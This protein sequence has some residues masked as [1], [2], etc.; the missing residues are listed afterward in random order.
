VADIAPHL[1]QFGILN[2]LNVNDYAI[3]VQGF[4]E[5]AVDGLKA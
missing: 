2:P 4:Q 1:V 5:L 3:R